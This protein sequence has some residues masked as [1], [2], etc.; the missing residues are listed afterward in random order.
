MTISGCTFAADGKYTMSWQNA[1]TW[2][3]GEPLPDSAVLYWQEDFDE[4]WI[5]VTDTDGFSLSDVSKCDPVGTYNLDA[6]QGTC[7]VSLT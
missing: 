6:G 5:D 4:W 7:V 3:N 1:C 2:D